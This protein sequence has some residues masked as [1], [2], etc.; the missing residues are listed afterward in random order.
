MKAERTRVIIAFSDITSFGP[1]ARR[2]EPDEFTTLMSKVYETFFDF[3]I[4]TGCVMKLLA[5]G[6]LAV[7]PLHS[8]NDQKKILSFLKSISSLTAHVNK[9]IGR[10]PH[11]RPRGFRTRVVIGSAW[12]VT[13][14]GGDVDFL[15]YQVNYCQRLLDVGRDGETLLASES[16]YDAL[17]RTNRSNLKFRK[18]PIQ[19][20]TLS[21]VDPE[22]LRS[23]YAFKLK[24]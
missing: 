17:G 23:V 11:P 6:F 9:I 3:Q 12:K 2:A 5:D 14:R 21:G 13:L 22:D 20:V 15:G 16:V 24:R 10:N 7:L 19:G 8:R 18:I 4:Q 1:W